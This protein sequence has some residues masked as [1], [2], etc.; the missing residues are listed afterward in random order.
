MGILEIFLI[1]YF[2][3]GFLYALYILLF[4]GDVW[5]WFP[6]NFI[7]GPIALIINF[8]T[9]LRGKKRRIL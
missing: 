7:F 2:L 4:A 5:Y 9:T 8:L 6:I 1:L 3:I